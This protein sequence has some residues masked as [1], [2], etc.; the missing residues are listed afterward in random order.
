[1]HARATIDVI[2]G[3]RKA[4]GSPSGAARGQAHNAC[5]QASGCCSRIAGHETRFSPTVGAR[6]S[7]LRL[8]LLCWPFSDMRDFQGQLAIRVRYLPLGVASA[9]KATSPLTI[10]ERS[11]C[12]PCLIVCRRHSSLSEVV[13]LLGLPK[14]MCPLLGQDSSVHRA[15]SAS[16]LLFTLSFVTL[17]P[18]CFHASMSLY[19][20]VHSTVYD[21]DTTYES[22]SKE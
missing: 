22:S 1:M 7:T 20:H 19:A 14:N 11:R 13:C 6:R 10:V 9:S 8:H 4:L 15:F 2:S 3:A 17:L 16:L 12:I 18:S 21:D 5:T